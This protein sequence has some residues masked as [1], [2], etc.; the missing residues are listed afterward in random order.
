MGGHVYDKKTLECIFDRLK[1]AY[2]ILFSVT[3]IYVPCAAIAYCYIRI[4]LYSYRA[5]DSINSQSNSH[6]RNMR[7]VNVAKSL[8]AS[9]F[10]FAICW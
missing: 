9:F 8:F 7:A 5:R 2:S 6:K 3:S 10:S 4:F 1:V